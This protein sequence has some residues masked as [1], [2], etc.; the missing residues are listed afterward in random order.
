MSAQ[1]ARQQ[2]GINYST[3]SST[4]DITRRQKGRGRDIEKR[5]DN[6]RTFTNP[7]S[8]IGNQGVEVTYIN[9]VTVNQSIV[10]TAERNRKIFEVNKK[11]KVHQANQFSNNTIDGNTLENNPTVTVPKQASK[12]TFIS[13]TSLQKASGKLKLQ[14]A[15]NG[16]RVVCSVVFILWMVPLI[17]LG[18]SLAGL[19]TE[20]TL[21]FLPEAARNIL[22]DFVSNSGRLLISF[23]YA[24]T[25]F[26]GLFVSLLPLVL[27]YYFTYRPAFGGYS[28]II[29][30]III[31]L[32]F[33]P[34][35]NVLPWFILWAGFVYLKIMAQKLKLA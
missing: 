25:V 22:P 26:F 32:Y 8:T 28:G 18:L 35:L 10:T 13:S 21:S 5:V 16:T 24:L 7:N 14:L 4:N 1:P 9:P 23:S 20:L 6:R 31:A 17:L 27:L 33:T 11:L 15:V 29:L 3:T 34:F 19:G 12:K 30:L 2:P